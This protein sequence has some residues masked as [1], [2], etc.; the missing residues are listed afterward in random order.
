MYPKNEESLNTSRK[1]GSE[2]IKDAE[3]SNSTA[4]EKKLSF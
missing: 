4:I 3:I 2:Y 1:N